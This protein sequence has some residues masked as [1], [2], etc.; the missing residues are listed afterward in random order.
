MQG[1]EFS[2]Q[3]KVAK[4]RTSYYVNVLLFVTRAWGRSGGDKIIVEVSRN[5]KSITVKREGE[6]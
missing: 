1:L 3:R 4:F 2:L 6:E 5:G